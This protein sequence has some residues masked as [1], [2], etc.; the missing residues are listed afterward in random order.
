MNVDQEFPEI[1]LM[2]EEMASLA[3]RITSMESDKEKAKDVE[4]DNS[5]RISVL[6]N[7]IDRHSSTLRTFIDRVNALEEAALVVSSS[8]CDYFPR[9]RSFVGWTYVLI[10][11]DQAMRR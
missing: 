3:A 8:L 10:N 5:I 4:K 9:S 6:E 7:I 2:R 1:T 11:Q